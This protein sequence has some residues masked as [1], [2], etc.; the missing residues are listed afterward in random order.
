MKA[1]NE[2]NDLVNVYFENTTSQLE[3]FTI[4]LDGSFTVKVVVTIDVSTLA[5]YESIKN[6]MITFD[7]EFSVAAN[8]LLS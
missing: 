5:T 8:Q 6:A 4:N 2:T 7:V 1:N 3:T